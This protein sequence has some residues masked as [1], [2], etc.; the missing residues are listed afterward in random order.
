MYALAED[1][2]PPLIPAMP[3]RGRSPEAASDAIGAG[4]VS[5]DR[6][7]QQAANPRSALA[8][9]GAQVSALLRKDGRLTARV[10]NPSE[11]CATVRLPGRTGSLVDLHGQ[12]IADFT[13]AFELGPSKIATIHVDE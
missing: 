8:I 5:T 6:M 13:D 1:A 3:R 12:A 2:F 9:S 11:V 7:R 10:F 4:D